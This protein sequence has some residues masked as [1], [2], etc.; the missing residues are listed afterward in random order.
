M[1]YLLNKKFPSNLQISDIV[2]S[3]LQVGGSFD[4]NKWIKTYESTLVRW[5]ETSN[6]VP[7]NFW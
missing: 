4:F 5:E 6:F 3:S 1:L 7:Q 2:E